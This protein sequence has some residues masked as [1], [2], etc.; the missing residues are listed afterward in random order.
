MGVLIHVKAFL[1]NFMPKLTNKQ[2]TFINK[3]FE[4]NF[5]ATKAALAAGYSENAARSIASENLTKPDIIDEIERRMNEHAMSANEVLYHLSAIGRGDMD[6]L[7][8]VRGN[9][10]L[11][12]ARQNKKTN[13][14]K[15]LHTET[16][17]V[18]DDRIKTVVTKIELYD[19][20]KALEL[21]AKHHDLI[22]RVKID[23]WRVQA[24]ADIRAGVIPFTALAEAFDIDLATELFK[25]A[26]V[27]VQIAEGEE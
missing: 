22:N 19:R 14:I 25:A 9:P 2:R 4:F 1:L 18:G 23:D 12:I 7:M 24:I 3:Y 10:S 16:I 8:D 6:D 26:G 17:P 11:K 27:P 15:K 20:L 5:N 21:L 13:L